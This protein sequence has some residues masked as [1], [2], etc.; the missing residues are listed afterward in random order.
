MTSSLTL[1]KCPIAELNAE[2]LLD[3]PPEWEFELSPNTYHIKN[4]ILFLLAQN[5]L[6]DP[7]TRNPLTESQLHSLS[8]KIGI[9]AIAFTEIWTKV[10]ERIFEEIEIEGKDSQSLM[11][12]FRFLQYINNKQQLNLLSRI[13]N[14]DQ[15][16]HNQTAFSSNAKELKKR[17]EFL[18]LLQVNDLWKG[19]ISESYSPVKKQLSL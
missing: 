3:I 2:D 8:K 14:L 12:N 4:L 5:K 16:L 18:S 9:K 13:K 15:I 10:E 11:N 7:F 1:K 6:I 19:K 17:E